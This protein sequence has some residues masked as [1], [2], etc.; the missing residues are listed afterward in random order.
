[1]RKNKKRYLFIKVYPEDVDVSKQSIWRS[2][3]ENL[4]ALIGSIGLADTNPCLIKDLDGG[5]GY[6]VISCNAKHVKD[7]IGAIALVK[8]V[9]GKKVS[10]DVIGISG[11]IKSIKSKYLLRKHLDV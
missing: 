2:I 9:N 4:T 10:L 8:E 6:L 5:K 11:T 1:M 7:V 3:L